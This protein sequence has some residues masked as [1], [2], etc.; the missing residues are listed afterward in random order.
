MSYSEDNKKT[1]VSYRDVARFTWHYWSRDKKTMTI[2][3]IGMAIAAFADT[4][5]PVVTGGFIDALH[6][7]QP[8]Q[9]RFWATVG[10]AFLAWTL[11]GF[12]YHSMRNGVLFIWNRFAIKCLFD[13][14]NEAFQKVQRFS[15]DWHANSFAGATVRK[16]TRA[17]WAFDVFEDIIF[18]NVFPSAIVM[19]SILSFATLKSPWLGL[20][21]F[22]SGAIYLALNV[23]MVVKINAPAFEKSAARDTTVGAQL[24]DIITANAVVKAFGSE[25]R[26]DQ[27]F[28]RVMQRWRLR[29]FR[30]WT[31]YILTDLLRRYSSETMAVVMVGTAVYLWSQ[32]E[33]TPGDVV[34]A[35]TSFMQ[36]SYYLRALGDNMANLQKSINDMADTIQFWMREDDMQDKKGAKDIVVPE[37]RIE[38]DKVHFAYQNKKRPLFDQLSLTISPGEKV[39]LVGHSGSGK[40]TFVKLVQRLY[41]IQGGEIRIDGQNVAE[42]TQDSLRSNIALVPQEPILFHRS[43]AANMAYARPNAT[44]DEIRDAARKAYA[45]EFIQ[46]LPSGYDTLVGERGV[47]LSG[48]E[49]QRVAI[50]RAILADA[51]ILILDEATASLDSISEHYIQK[52]L[53]NLIKGRTTITVAHRLS[54]IQNADRILVF[55]H[56]RIVEEGRHD[57][58]IHR[59]GSHYKELYDMQ[60][61]DLMDINRNA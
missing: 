54:T 20:A 35:L 11:L 56:G 29:A 42:V 7:Y 13:I 51:P 1:Y 32:G 4:L 17:K 48:G 49:R 39:A 9:N 18:I 15:S 45:D 14:E 2:V 60:A 46:D 41:D 38:F 40:S 59:E 22:I 57:D 26:E 37:G 30:S 61:M 6:E 24:A 44:M 34:F 19:V 52:A 50:A 31:L 12:A 23:F 25:K 10:P 58:L 5:L 21:T 47:K 8:E 36:L 3:F 16:I 27:R 43:I 33:L 53:A 55:D 28:E